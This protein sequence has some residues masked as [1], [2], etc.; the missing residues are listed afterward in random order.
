MA[1]YLAVDPKDPTI[2]YKWVPVGMLDYDP[3]S[4][5]YLVQKCDNMGRIVDPTG[6]PVVNGG[7]DKDG[8]WLAQSL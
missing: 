5:H 8:K 4:G 3:K 7:K 2:E 1:C 6:Q